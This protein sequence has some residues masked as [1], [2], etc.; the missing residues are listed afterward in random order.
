MDVF[1]HLPIAA[2][3]CN[4]I[5]C[6]HGGLS[7][8]LFLPK[9]NNYNPNEIGQLSFDNNIKQ[10]QRPTDIGDC[11]L[12]CDLLWSDPSFD[13]NGFYDNWDRGVSY[14]FGKD[15]VDC[16]NKNFNIDLICRGYQAVEDG[17]E[18]FNKRKLVTVFSAPN[19]C[20]EFDN[21]A[22]FR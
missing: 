22:A 5:F 10:I 2:T 15:I 3:V 18:F 19:Y 7:P 20:G 11:G 6:V 14:Y 4:K 17:Y 13:I 12:V 21:C 16:F 9:D 8:Q 1:N